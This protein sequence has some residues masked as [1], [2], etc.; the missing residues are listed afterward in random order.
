MD[1]FDELLDEIE[2][3]LTTGQKPNKKQPVALKSKYTIYSIGWLLD[4]HADGCTLC[5]RKVLA[6]YAATK[7]GKVL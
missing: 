5:C 1:D 3:D 7:W 4:K 2:K 6:I